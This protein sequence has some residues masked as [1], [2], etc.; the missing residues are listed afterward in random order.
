MDLWIYLSCVGVRAF[1]C[2]VVY[3]AVR[4]PT[5]SA[6][7]KRCMNMTE[8]TSKITLILLNVFKNSR[9]KIKDKCL[10]VHSAFHLPN[11][12]SLTSTNQSTRN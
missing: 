4:V 8:V 10:I 6:F 3:C 5:R 1:R 7:G 2:S 11:E 12:I 9:K